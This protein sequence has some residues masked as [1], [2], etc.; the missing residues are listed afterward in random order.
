MTNSLTILNVK[1][2]GIPL[3]NAYNLYIGYKG[4][5]YRLQVDPEKLNIVEIPDFS[6]ENNLSIQVYNSNDGKVYSSELFHITD[7]NGIMTLKIHSIDIDN[8]IEELSCTFNYVLED[9][10][11]LIECHVD[12]SIDMI[13]NKYFSSLSTEIYTI[14]K[15][16]LFMTGEYNQTNE[17]NLANYPPYNIHDEGIAA[18]TNYIIHEHVYIKEI[19]LAR[20]ELTDNSVPYLIELLGCPYLKELRLFTISENNFTSK[21]I[22]QLLASFILRKEHIFSSLPSTII[23]LG[24]NSC[25]MNDDCV[26]LFLKCVRMGIFNNL[27][28][29]WIKDNTFTIEGLTLLISSLL[30]NSL[31]IESIAFSENLIDN[32][33]SLMLAK[34]IKE[35]KQNYCGLEDDTFKTIINSILENQHKL[36]VLNVKLNNLTDFSLE[37]IQSILCSKSTELIH[38]LNFQDNGSKEKRKE[39]KYAILDKFNDMFVWA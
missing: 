20:N 13:C 36:N 37:Y 4:N 3:D 14:F 28:E 18:L 25:H 38:E 21:G 12:S 32:A 16:N 31:F 19:N 26:S 10:S 33:C 34:Y 30:R 11:Q 17:I 9:I 1:I 22:M 15:D 6:Y 7:K 5:A 27:Q 2:D 39:V 8:V 24:F 23:S 35:D 29:L